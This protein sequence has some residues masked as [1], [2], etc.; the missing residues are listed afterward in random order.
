VVSS[1]RGRAD[2]AGGSATQGSYE[3]TPGP[4][5]RLLFAISLGVFVLLAVCVLAW[6]L[7]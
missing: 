5:E 2:R 4:N 6:S 7:R 3:A 1:L